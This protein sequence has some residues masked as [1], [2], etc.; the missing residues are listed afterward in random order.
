MNNIEQASL[1][2]ALERLDY[3]IIKYTFKEQKVFNI[4]AFIT[5]YQKLIS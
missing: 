3:Y 5:S 4:F 1:N 2:V